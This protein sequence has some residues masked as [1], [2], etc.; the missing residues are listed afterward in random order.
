MKWALLSVWD[1]T[2]IVELAQE[3]LQQKFSIMSSGGTG[4]VLT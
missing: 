4:K 3:I 2:G 1:K